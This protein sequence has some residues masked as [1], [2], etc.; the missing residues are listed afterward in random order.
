M[1]GIEGEQVLLRLIVS[2]SRRHEHQPLFQKLVDILRAEGLAGTT[3][4][5]G[6]AGF[7]HDRQL[8]TI[9]LEVAS[10]GLPVV[11]E[12]VDS[13]EHIDRV[14]PQLERV[15]QGGAITMERARVIRYSQS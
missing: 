6:I 8:H 3:V 9:S 14:L 13:Q 1:R 2:E 5:K 10:I 12:V 11:I 7:G 4:L 15:M